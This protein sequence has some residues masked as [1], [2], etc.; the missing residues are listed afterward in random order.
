VNYANGPIAASYSSLKNDFVGVGTGSTTQTVNT[1]GANYTMGAAKFFLLN[2][3]NKTNTNSVDNNT[4]SVSAAYTMGAT[5]LM[6]QVGELKNKT[7]LKSKMS[8]LGADYSLSKRTV[9][10]ARY[11]S[12]DDKASVIAAAATIDGTGTKRTRTAIGVRHSF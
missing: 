3:T 4:T 2:Q 8:S 9:A 1:F 7:G 11:E 5:T 10:Y 6:A 12:I